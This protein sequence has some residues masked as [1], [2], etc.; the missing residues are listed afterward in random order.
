VRIALVSLLAPTDDDP[1][2]SLGLLQLAGKTLAA[3][4]LELALRLGCE[5]VIC[6]AAGFDRQ[7]AALQH[8]AEAAGAKFSQVSGPRALLGMVGGTDELVGFA[9]GLLPAADEAVVALADGAGVLVL[10]VEAGLAAGFERIDLNHAWAGMFVMPG[11]LVERLSELPPDCDA[12]S[13]LLRIALQG[14]V[15]EKNLPEAVLAEGRWVMVQSRAQLA[16]MEPDWFRRHA[17]RLSF[18]APGKSLARFATGKWAGI[19]LGR[20]VKPGSFATLG[21]AIAAVGVGAA[22][23]GLTVAG[24]VACGLG[25]LLVECGTA[26][27]AIANA[28]SLAERPGRFV[29]AADWLIDLYIVAALVPALPG[30]L[31]AGIVEPALLLGLLRLAERLITPKWAE[32]LQDRALLTAILAVSASYGMLMPALEALSLLVLGALLGFASRETRL[33]QA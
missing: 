20:G 24:I 23:S 7:A 26:L 11:R 33:T 15:A 3:R 12:V 19:L 30:A 14:R 2:T 28:G 21:I 13:A 9:D 1:A 8:L 5:K 16:T 10:P 27:R 32:L 4:Q 6:V 18:F 25:W 29:A 31:P 17:A 22:W